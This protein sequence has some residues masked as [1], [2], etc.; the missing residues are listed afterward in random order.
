V[1]DTAIAVVQFLFIEVTDST[2]I[3]MWGQPCR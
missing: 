1:A 3:I 2:L